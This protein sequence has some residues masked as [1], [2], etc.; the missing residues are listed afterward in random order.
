[1]IFIFISRPISIERHP[2]LVKERERRAFIAS[3]ER[4]FG[5]LRSLRIE[6]LH[7]N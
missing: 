1:V 3:P 7:R 6:I 2:R 5:S 4:S